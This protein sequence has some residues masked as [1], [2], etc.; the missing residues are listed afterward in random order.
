MSL[1]ILQGGLLTTVQDFG[2]WGY[3]QYGMSLSGVM[4]TRS[5]SLANILVG[6]SPQ[7]GL[8]EITILGPEIRFTAET[9]I[10]LT[11][12]NLSPTLNGVSVPLYQEF[13]VFPE[14]ILGFSTLTSGCRCYLAVS[15]GL[16]IPMVMGSYST[17]LRGQVGG[18]QGRKLEKGDNIPLKTPNPP[19]SHWRCLPC[20]DF[21]SSEK[22]VRVVM[23][24]QDSA[25]TE[26]GI[27]T[28]LRETYTITP[29]ND[30]MGCRLDGKPIAH[31]HDANIISD[32][33]VFGSVQIP[34]QGTPIIMLADCQT[35][36]GYTKIATVI[37]VDLPLIAQSKTGERLRFQSISVEYAQEL[38]CD[39]QKKQFF[40][41]EEVKKK[42]Q[43]A[44]FPKEIIEAVI[45]H[46]QGVYPVSVGNEI[47]TCTVLEV[48]ETT[49]STT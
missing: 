41:Q 14:D 24:P 5:A 20:E 48:D 9:S 42:P 10:A 18:F 49:L 11:G 31:K 38:A 3:Q 35:T 30:R 36:G 32:G 17:F 26:E 45:L 2:R 22:M 33:I 12:G 37:S 29:E 27:R 28:F 25:F 7:E 47:Y 39:W 46:G 34:D 8:L 19:L 6:N 43:D 40:Y 13:P 4:D 15:G 16:D 1:E 23:G 21:S 44:P